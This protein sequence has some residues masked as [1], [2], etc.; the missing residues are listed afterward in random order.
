MSKEPKASAHL[1]CLSTTGLDIHDTQTSQ[2][3]T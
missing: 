2:L 3:F 1:A